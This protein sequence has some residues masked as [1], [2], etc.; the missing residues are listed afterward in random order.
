MTPKEHSALEAKRLL[1]DLTPYLDELERQVVEEMVRT[2]SWDESSDR[3]RRC[4]AD[5]I[6]AIRD[7]K[8]KLESVITVGAHKRASRGV[9]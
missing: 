9:V 2:N 8:V 7:V 6:Q 1:D 3:K 5:Q 4:L